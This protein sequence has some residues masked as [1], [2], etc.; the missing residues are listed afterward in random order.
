M[1]KSTDV[2][3]SIE[4]TD[5]EIELSAQDLFA[6]SD[7]RRTDEHGAN[8]T[9]EPSRPPTSAP[10]PRL[11]RPLLL[12][13]AIGVA[14]TLYVLTQSAG[15]SPSAADSSEQTAPSQSPVP[16]QLAEGE[17]VRFANPFDADEVFEFPPGT[18]QS[19]ARDAVADVL[20]K[21]AV[22]RQKT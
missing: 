11:R 13:A 6:L 15:V 20:L 2:N 17:V 14:G 10:L 21:R 3:A 16:Q 5:A 1:N 18:S 19:Q 22:S 4:E 9:L 8:P 12:S 7:P